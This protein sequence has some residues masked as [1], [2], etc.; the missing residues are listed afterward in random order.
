MNIQ[1]RPAAADILVSL[2]LKDVNPG[3][4][5]GPDGWSAADPA[6]AFAS[7][8]PA[9]EQP[10]ALITPATQA[11]MTRAIDVAAET[12]KS[13]RMVPAPKRGELIGRIGE[14]LHANKDALGALLALETGKSLTEGKG[15]IGEMV[16]MAKFAVGQSRMLYGFTM[17]SQRDEHRM[18][19]QWLPL[20]V[21]GIITAY[22]FPAA[23][24]SW[25]ALVAAICGNTVVWKPSPKVAL[26]AIAIQHLCNQAMAELGYPGVFSL[27]IPSDE[28]I[29]ESLVRDKRVS[30]VSFTGS[31]GIGRKVAQIVSGD[32]GRRHLLECS[33]NNG[34]ILDETAD[35]D[36]S[37]AAITFGALGTT[38]QRCT[39]TRRLIVHKS[40]TKEVVERLK[41]AYDKVKVGDPFTPGTLIG[42]IIDKPAVAAFEKAVAE[43]KA[44]GGEVVYG[45]NIIPGPGYFVEPTI[46][47]AKNEWPCVQ[48]E[49]FAP[50]LYVIEYETFDEALDIHNSVPQ[51]L[52]S[53]IQST[54]IR[55][56]EAF[57]SARGSDCGIAKVNMGTTG[58]D[59]GAAFGGEKETGGGR[60]SGSESWKAYMR[61]QSVAINWGS[62][63]PWRKLLQD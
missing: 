24:W 38:G 61:R 30:L 28:T 56:I 42:P 54:D 41:R 27:V 50:I 58:A 17:Q 16:D 37:I 55:H 46:I 48:H 49:T 2:G 15:E 33:G 12:F 11:E 53:G 59:I 32:L 63:T 45:G 13:W 8:N 6:N 9:T 40:R 3:A 18:Y 39:S 5:H 29:S 47:L 60:A 36:L 23:P 57:L 21:V 19:D 52:A 62:E 34:C 10:I 20:G 44:L 22:N 26:P 43:A 4:C 35:L 7:I 31:S 14:L 1:I 51:G 25:N